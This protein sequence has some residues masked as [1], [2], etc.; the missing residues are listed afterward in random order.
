MK[1]MK[2]YRY[3]AAAGITLAA[4]MTGLTAN[5]AETGAISSMSEQV[6]DSMDEGGNV[7]A[8]VIYG[9]TFSLVSAEFDAA[10][11]VWYYV[12]TPTGQS[13]YIKS[14]NV[15]VVE[16][17]ATP[18]TTV[19]T[20]SE[21]AS[22]E[23][24]P[25]QNVIDGNNAVQNEPE[26]VQQPTVN[27]TTNN[28]T[29]NNTTNNNTTNNNTANNTNNN[30]TNNNTANNDT[31]NSDGDEGVV[32]EINLQLEVKQTANIRED[33][34]TD[35]EALGRIPQGTVITSTKSKINSSGETWYEVEYNGIKGYVMDTV[36][37]VLG[38]TVEESTVETETAAPV[39]TVTYEQAHQ[40]TAAAS[41]AQSE[42]A[43]EN[44]DIESENN[45]NDN[46][47]TEKKKSAVYINW[48]L[49][50]SLLGIAVFGALLYRLVKKINILIEN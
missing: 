34:S 18:E 11:Q 28:T 3:I 23:T 37:E 20:T 4:G 17:P 33:A 48:L 31:V 14:D 43:S 24:T 30:T 10:G 21:G 16:Q 19:D 22:E 47:G 1:H 45:S 5:A 35:D 13:G 41:E 25:D 6:Y 49:I 27:T 12:E 40:N 29:T 42:V 15:Y 38:E 36:V 46:E 39:E 9:S 2:W 44:V 50:L 26:A 32:N 8:N 7:V